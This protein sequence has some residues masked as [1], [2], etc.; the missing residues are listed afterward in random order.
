MAGRTADLFT[1]PEA[2]AILAVFL[3]SVATYVALW[4]RA[5]DP[6]LASGR[7]ERARLQRQVEWLRERAERARRENWDAE[8]MRRFELEL[9]AAQ[10]ELAALV[11]PSER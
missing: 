2:L 9:A 10:R 8:M 6:A 11:N 4:L 3:V 7:A 5:R 1:R